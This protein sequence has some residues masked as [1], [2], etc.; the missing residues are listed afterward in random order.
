MTPSSRLTA[1]VG[2]PIFPISAATRVGL[3]ALL[4]EV[5]AKLQVLRE[6]EARPEPNSPPP[7]IP[8]HL[9]VDETVS[10]EA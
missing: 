2:Q 9:R 7:Q 5:W 3:P 6:Q 1:A 10:S 8:P 4:A